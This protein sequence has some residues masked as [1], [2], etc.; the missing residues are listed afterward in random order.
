MC[1]VQKLVTALVYDHT[2]I[3]SF[4]SPVLF[5]ICARMTH[6]EQMTLAWWLTASESSGSQE[7]QQTWYTV[8]WYTVIPYW[9]HLLTLTWYL[10]GQRLNLLQWKNVFQLM[11]KS[12]DI[13]QVW[14]S[15]Y[16]T[17]NCGVPIQA[18]VLHTTLGPRRGASW[19]CRSWEDLWPRQ[20]G[21]LAIQ[22]IEFIPI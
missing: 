5:Q 13:F 16:P 21:P 10:T 19:S 15:I 9:H 17:H 2:R 18:P 4:S 22:W 8:T 3:V 14:L 20:E 1:L 11:N 7:F 12:V 6:P